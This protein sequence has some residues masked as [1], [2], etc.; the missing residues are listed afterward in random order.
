MAIALVALLL[1]AQPAGAYAATPDDPYESM[2]RGFYA[3]HRALDAVIF[4]PAARAY[5]A[6]LPAQLR[7]GFH[8]MIT[9]LKEPGIAA[10]DLLQAHPARSGKTVVRFVVNSTVGLAGLFD[11]ANPMGF[12]HHDN[13]FGTTA[14]RYNVQPGPYLFI[15]LVGPTNFR[16]FLGYIADAVTDPLAFQPFHDGQVIYARAI[17]DGLDQRA[18]ADDQLRAIDDMSTDPYASLR[19]LFEQNRAG[20]IHDAVTG[21]TGSSEPD[22]DNFDDPGAAPPPAAA[23]AAEEKPVAFLAP[24]AAMDRMVEDML[25]RP[26]APMTPKMLSAL[27]L[28]AVESPPAG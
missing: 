8:N 23:P 11:F 10:N 5:K 9:N 26:L 19:S 20:Q 17:V 13:G 6:V 3:V 7:K 21:V 2:N 12:P 1:A 14:G 15:P 18:Q 25:A 22:L 27:A 28:P 4:G 24:D 16:D